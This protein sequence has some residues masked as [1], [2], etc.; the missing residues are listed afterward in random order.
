MQKTDLSKTQKH[1]YKA[2]AV[3]ELVTI[4]P[5]HY[6]TIEGMGDPNADLFFAKVKAMYSTAYNIKKIHKLQEQ[7]F[8]VAAMEAYWWTDS[9]AQVSEVSPELWRWKIVIQ[10][11][12]Y[13][14][15]LDFKQAVALAGKKKVP[16][17]NEMRFER[18]AGSKA[19]QIL[20]IGSYHQEFPSIEKML[21]YAKE[22]QLEITGRHHEIYITDPRKTPEERLRTIL[23]YAVK[24]S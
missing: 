12:D 16:H 15:A 8:K 21:V 3:P 4:A 5:A 22:H 9:G 10:L 23:R 20:H 18:I 1:Y 11:P 6:L 17:L 13:V 14:T 7:D 24:K 19:I 2:K